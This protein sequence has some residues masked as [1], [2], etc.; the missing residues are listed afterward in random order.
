[1]D[2]FTIDFETHYSK[3]YSLSK[4]LTEEYVTDPRFEFILVSKKKNDEKTEWF[5]GPFKEIFK[6]MYYKGCFARDAAWLGHHMMF[7]CLC[8]AVHFKFVPRMIFDTRLMAQAVLRPYMRSVSLDACLKAVDL[9]IKKGTAV[10]NYIGYTRSM[11]SPQELK[12]YG[13][14]GCDDVEG[15]YALFK[16]MLPQFPR[17]ELE[18][19]D[20]TLRMYLQPK[21]I[22]DPDLLAELLQEE[23]ARKT[24]LMNSLPADVQKADV[25]SNNKFAE[26]LMRYGV[27]PPLKISPTTGES[28][29]AFSK[30]DTG[31][32]ELEEEYEDDEV[33]SAILTARVGLKSTLAEA[34]MERLLKIATTFDKLRVPLLYY[35]AHTGREGGMEKINMQNPPRI[36]KSRMRFAFR[37]PAGHVVLGLDLAQIEARITAWLAGQTDLVE[38]FRQKVDVYSKFATR[39]FKC[40]TIKGRSKEDDKRRFVGK[41]CILGLGF[42]MG[43]PKLKGTLRKDGVKVD[44]MESKL[45]VDTYR[46]TYPRIPWLWRILDSKLSMMA[47]GGSSSTLGPVTLMKNSIMLPNDMQIVYHNLRHVK[48]ESNTKKYQGW[49]YNFGGEVRTVWGGKVTENIVQALARILVMDYML[50][51]KNELGLLPSL[52]VH[53]ELDYVIP[54]SQVDEVSQACSEIMVVPPWWAPDLP[55]AVEANYGPTFGDCK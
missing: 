12:H 17:K 34:R 24:Q 1:M 3:E 54:E 41:T 36:D 37:A 39:A 46:D 15:T 32:K 47:A 27:Q 38:D 18:I 7:D 44:E 20:S 43:A 22:A 23:R 40:E 55:V 52:R 28:T 10:H 51:I 5:S 33:I 35:A 30:N 9:G 16:Y 13:A 2:L 6:W 19:I 45:Y 25:M 11:F 49:V 53:D 31:F 29:Y 4:M 50:T 42:G 8:A 21:L 14:Y 48:A 26:V